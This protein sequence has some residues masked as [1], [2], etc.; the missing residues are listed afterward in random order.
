MWLCLPAPS[1]TTTL[2]LWRYASVTQ[3]TTSRAIVCFDAI[4]DEL[5]ALRVG[6]GGRQ[7]AVQEP[8]ASQRRRAG[9]PERALA[10]TGA[11]KRRSASTTTS[12]S[13]GQFVVPKRVRNTRHYVRLSAID[14]NSFVSAVGRA[15]ISV[16]RFAQVAR[17]AAT[18]SS[19]SNVK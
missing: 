14:P 6:L 19:P 13:T 15:G 17:I 7:T 8:A 12:N 1:G 5:H 2:L 16:P 18:S 9:S 4:G 3:S 11:R 10:M